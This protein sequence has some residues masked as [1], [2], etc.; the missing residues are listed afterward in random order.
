MPNSKTSGNQ[1][2]GVA[3]PAVTEAENVMRQ[4]ALEGFTAWESKNQPAGVAAPAVTEAEGVLRQATGLA[5]VLRETAGVIS[6]SLAAERRLA[7]ALGAAEIAAEKDTAV[8]LARQLAATRERREG[9]VRRRRAA[10]EGLVA[11]EGALQESRRG[12]DATRSTLA[13]G[14]V[15]ELQA[16]WARAVDE[17]AAVYAEVQEV[18]RVTYTRI[19]LPAPYRVTTNLVSGVPGLQFT[20]G[21]ANP[22]AGLPPALTALSE[23][24]TKLDVAAATAGGIR[25][26]GEADVRHYRL[27]VERR[28]NGSTA[29]VYTVVKPVS[30]LGA[31]F[32]RGTLVDSSVIN[33]GTLARYLMGHYVTEAGSQPPAA[34]A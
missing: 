22:P 12:V 30:F 24:I 11:M 29:S 21:A 33:P 6:E 5:D 10:S 8:Q 16:R 4:A 32:E 18:A 23:L 26:A 28:V 1:P 20:A 14:M 2:A 27:A 13:G 15:A 34:A 25:Q 9:A 7:S 17:L 31:T 3:A 19:D